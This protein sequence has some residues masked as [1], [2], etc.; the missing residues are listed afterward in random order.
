VPKP[1][2]KSR[3]APLKERLLAILGEPNYQPLD[4]VQLGKKLGVPADLRHEFRK[5]LESLESNGEIARIRKNFYVLPDTANLF[6]GRITFT[7]RGFAFVEN[8]IKGGPDLFIAAENTATAMHGDTV[9]ARI[10]HE[11]MEEKAGGGRPRRGG[12]RGGGDRHEG[13]VIRILNSANPTL[14][15]TLNQARHFFYVVADEPRIVQNIVVDPAH[16]ACAKKPSVG[17][18]VVVRLDPWESRHRAPEGVITEVLGQADAPGVDMLAIIKKHHLPEKFPDAVLRQADETSE[19]IPASE[20][21]Q[22][23][24]FRGGFI[25]TIDPDDARDHD[26]AITVTPLRDGWRLEVHIADVSHY[27]PLGSPLDKEALKRGNSVYLADR[28]IPML[29]ERLSNGICS[30]KEGVDRLTGAVVIEFDKLGNPR[31]TRFAR[32]I[33]CAKARLTYKMAFAMLQAKP[34][35]EISQAV[36]NAWTLAAILRKNRFANGALD[37]DMPDV[38]VVLDDKG[39]P[40]R[41]DKIEN[42]I[43]H[44]LVEEFMLMANEAVA[45]AI[46]EAP[47]RSIFR[48]H[49]PP[50]NDRLAEFRQ[51]AISYG[52]RVGDLSNRTEIQKLLRASRGKPEENVIRIGLLK[53]LKRACYDT[54]PIGHYGLAKTFY[55]HFTSPIRRYADLVVHRTLFDTVLARGKAKR[56]DAATMDLREAAIHISTTERT[57]A[58]AEKESVR[59]KKLEYLELQ[60]GGV[61]NRERFP[62]AIIDIKSYGLLVELP[63]FLLTGLIHV[64]ELRDD[65]FTFDA[66]RLRFV[67][68]K[69]KREYIIGQEIE[70]EVVKVDKIKRQVDFRPSTPRKTPR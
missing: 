16:S 68:R 47:A 39:T 63:Q 5:E 6:S 50:D 42:D 7:D 24:D 33:I 26:D 43:S 45:R 22:R 29:P 69:T 13:R 41:L 10:T 8:E 37:L 65:F 59:L 66:P 48:V 14:V 36:H 60:A 18:K 3:Q 15:G 62:A 17:E 57:A 58:D 2:S 27:V 19:T 20:I 21:A 49:E 30:L 11:G 67:G 34:V 25:V 44:Q 51:F 40:I 55:T 52:Y 31:R 38:K 12:P 70:V 28:V 54:D 64:S 1:T 23:E 56:R 4:K 32:G 35:D 46:Q 53:S 9:L 61:K